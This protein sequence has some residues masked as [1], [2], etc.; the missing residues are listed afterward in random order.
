VGTTSA[1]ETGSSLLLAI[2][3]L[4]LASAKTTVTAAVYVAATGVSATT[5]A[6]IVLEARAAV[7]S[8][9]RTLLFDVHARLDDLSR[10]GDEEDEEA[11]AAPPERFSYQP[12]EAEL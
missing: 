3:T 9:F 5:G 8:R 10:L 2:A 4:L 11:E 1:S 6:V 12:N 7:D